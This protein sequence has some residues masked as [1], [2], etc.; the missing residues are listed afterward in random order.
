MSFPLDTVRG[1]SVRHG[2]K[3]A[4]GHRAG[5]LSLKVIIGSLKSHVG[6]PVG[7]Q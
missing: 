5:L 3:F 6:L 2:A 1:F 4:V 7:S